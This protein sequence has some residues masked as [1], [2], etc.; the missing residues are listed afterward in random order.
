MSGFHT[1]IE[2]ETLKNNNFRKVIFTGKYTQLVLMSLKP[3][4][5]IGLETHG[6]VDQFFRFEA[7]YGKVIIDK[8]EYIVKANDVIIV[9]AGS[10]HNIIN[11]SDSENLKIYTLYSPPNH[12][13]GTIHNTKKEAEEYEKTEH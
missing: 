12:P 10:S 6:N 13:D 1:N 2:E 3:S 4:E 11:T 9:P 8:D 7:G 5:D